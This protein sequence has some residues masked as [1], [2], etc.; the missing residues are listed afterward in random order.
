LRIGAI[1]VFIKRDDANRVCAIYDQ[2]TSETMD[3]LA[4][5][6][7]EV[8]EFL[9]KCTLDNK[10]PFLKSDLELIRVVEDLI[11]ILLAKNI[12]SITDFPA[13]AVD[14]LVTR[15]KIREQFQGISYIIGDEK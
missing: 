2:K 14:K 1:M 11:Q 7:P 12:I 15:N 8:L 9:V 6:D 3:E 10:I 4:C 13:P 5:D